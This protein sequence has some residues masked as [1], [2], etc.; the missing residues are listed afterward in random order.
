[1]S[2]AMCPG[3]F[4]PITNGHIDVIERAAKMFDKVVVV[5]MVNS[6]KIGSHV[7][8]EE[9]RVEMIRKATKNLPNV[10]VDTYAGLLVNYAKD[11]DI[12]IVVKGLRASS[13]FEYEFQQALGNRQ[14]SPELETV[15]I[16]TKAENMFVSSSIVR[17]IG[18]MGGDISSFVPS[19][20]LEEL[21]TKLRKD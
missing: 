17:Q 2:I 3:S 1:M 9:E 10:T 6:R 18:E 5:V 14:L 13:D 15:F 11:H 21:K 19:E 4:D 20:V 8:S 16:P 7:F 12:K